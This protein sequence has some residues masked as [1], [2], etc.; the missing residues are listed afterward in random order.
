MIV[1]NLTQLQEPV[2]TR[3]IPPI[4]M[5]QKNKNLIPDHATGLAKKTFQKALAELQIEPKDCKIVLS[6][7]NTPLFK[8]QA[9]IL[10][11]QWSQIFNIPIKLES[12]EDKIYYQSLEN[13]EFTVALSQWMVQYSD[14]MNILERFQSKNLAKNAPGWEEPAYQTLLHSILLEKDSQKR[15]K[16]IE[17]AEVF[18][19]EEMPVCPIYHYYYSSMCQPYVKDLL[20]DILGGV[21]FETAKI[22]KNES[23]R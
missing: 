14:P 9:E 20:I 16:L 15:T 1:K 23:D 6:Y 7:R 3:L 2:G 11:Q 12:L 21:H 22:F 5:N 4:L 17:Q 8:L 13:H 10:Q 18:L 19:L